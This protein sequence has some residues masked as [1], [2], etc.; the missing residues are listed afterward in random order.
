MD[1]DNLIDI[2]GLLNWYI[3]HIIF[4]FVDWEWIWWMILCDIWKYGFEWIFLYY[5]QS[6]VM[7]SFQSVI[8][9][10][11]W[12]WFVIFYWILLIYSILSILSISI[13]LMMMINRYYS[14]QLIW[15]IWI[16]WIYS[17]HSNCLNVFLWWRLYCIHLSGFLIEIEMI[18]DYLIKIEWISSIDHN[19]LICG[20]IVQHKIGI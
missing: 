15:M 1:N 13:W 7:K 16:S 10:S 17:I 14:F 4:Y 6:F 8:L 9:W 18:D 2:I 19:H 3:F 20:Y 11:E 5:L 12:W